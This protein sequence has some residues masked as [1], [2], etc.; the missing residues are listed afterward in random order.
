MSRRAMDDLALAGIGDFPFDLA[1]LGV[2]WVKVWEAALF[3]RARPQP[4]HGTN[5]PSLVMPDGREL[6]GQGLHLGRELAGPSF[7]RTRPVNRLL[8]CQ[9][10]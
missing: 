5:Q 8:F 7:S 2:S 6:I 9:R 10:K 4:F 3:R 1:R